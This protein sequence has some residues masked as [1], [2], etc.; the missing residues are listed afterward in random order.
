[1]EQD[2][3]FFLNYKWKKIVNSSNSNISI[4]TGA[5]SS[6]GALRFNTSSTASSYVVSP[7][8]DSSIPLNT[9]KVKFK[10][11]IQYNTHKLIVGVMSNPT[12]ANTFVQIEELH[13]NEANTWKDIEVLFNSYNG[14][15]QYI[16]FKSVNNSGICNIYVDDFEISSLPSCVRPTQLNISNIT[17]TS[18]DVAL[19]GVNVNQWEIEYKPYSDTSWQNAVRVSN[20]TTNHLLFPIYH[21]QQ[22]FH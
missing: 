15:G 3:L 14:N 8:V 10:L 21:H 7:K 9:T 1:M 2:Q 19:N 20:I 4:S 12:D 18:M 6:P 17:P 13:L 5:F 22:F 16:A 11:R